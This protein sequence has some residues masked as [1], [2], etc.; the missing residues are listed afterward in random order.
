ML[1]QVR[2]G[3]ALLALIAFFVG[4]A[5]TAAHAAWPMFRGT[6]RQLGVAPGKLARKLK[7]AWKF[8]TQGALTSSADPATHTRLTAEQNIYGPLNITGSLN[9]LGRPTSSKSIGAGFKFDW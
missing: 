8:K 3:V 1:R 6:S 2:R 5:A 9:D 7:L 4:V